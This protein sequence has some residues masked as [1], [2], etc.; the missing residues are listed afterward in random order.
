MSET[1]FTIGHSTHQRSSE[2]PACYENGKVQYDR[3][4]MTDLFRQDLNV[5]G[6]EQESTELL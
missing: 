5:Y 1:V 6:R 4:A 3:L 2:D